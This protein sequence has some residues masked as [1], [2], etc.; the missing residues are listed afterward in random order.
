MVRPLFCNYMMKNAT[1]RY[2]AKKNSD[3]LLVFLML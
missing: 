1:G 2:P 3:Q